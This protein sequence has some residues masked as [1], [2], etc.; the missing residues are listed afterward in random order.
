LL[1]PSLKDK[2]KERDGPFTLETVCMIGLQ[3][4]CSVFLI[5]YFQL[6]RLENFHSIG[7]IHL[8]IKPDNILLGTGNMSAPKSRTLYLIDFG[9]SKKFKNPDGTHIPFRV[10]LPFCGN[11]I[12]ASLNSFLEYGKH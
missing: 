1:G 3:L 9:V 2:L 12:F 6:E 5:S 8:D 11:V 7:Y 4:V 10:D